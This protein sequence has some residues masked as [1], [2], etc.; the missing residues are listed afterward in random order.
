MSETGLAT[1]FLPSTPMQVVD[2][3]SFRKRRTFVVCGPTDT[4]QPAFRWSGSRFANVSHDGCVDLFNFGCVRV[5]YASMPSKC[6]TLDACTL[7]DRGSR[8]LML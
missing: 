5:A 8:A 4:D 3:E 6:S 2:R 7:S 1:S